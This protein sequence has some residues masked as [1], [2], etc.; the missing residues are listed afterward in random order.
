M[1]VLEFI[2]GIILIVA[3]LFIAIGTVGM[4][5]NTKQL[6][7]EN[8]KLREALDKKRRKK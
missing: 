5:Y 7:E 4:K 3:V 1:G 8:K 6:E 2:F